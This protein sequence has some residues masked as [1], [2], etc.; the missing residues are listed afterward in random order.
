LTTID[1]H[2]DH[3]VREGIASTNNGVLAIFQ[4]LRFNPTLTDLNLDQ[5]GPFC[6]EAMTFAVDT[7]HHLN[8][9]LENLIGEDGAQ[10][11]ANEFRMKVRVNI[12]DK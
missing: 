10:C 7:Q 3:I 12:F 6:K 11:L 2:D 4:A 8:G 5:F 1:L 9:L